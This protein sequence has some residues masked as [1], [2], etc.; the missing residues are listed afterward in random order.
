MTVYLIQQM[1]TAV[2]TVRQFVEF[3]QDLEYEEAMWER[4]SDP[5]Y[6]TK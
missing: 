2:S 3:R 1:K 5:K 6:A 4:R